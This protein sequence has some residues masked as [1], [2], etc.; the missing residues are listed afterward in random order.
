MIEEDVRVAIDAFN[1][2]RR[3]DVEARLL[4]IEGQKA[5]VE[6]VGGRERIDYYL[7]YFREKLETITDSSVKT[8]AVEKNGTCV[9][10]FFI[11]AIKKGEEDPLQTALKILD[12]YNEG[13]P[14]SGLDFED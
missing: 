10:R 7:N 9:A 4:N 14:A 1:R 6:F 2:F 5:V 12:K 13:A 3:P 11:A 8:E